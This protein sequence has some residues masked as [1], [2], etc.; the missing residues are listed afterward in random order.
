MY[1]PP[2]QQLPPGGPGTTYVIHGG[3]DAGARFDGNAPPSIPPPP[4]GIAPN[5]AQMAAAS[6]ANVHITQQQGDWMTGGSDGGY[7]VW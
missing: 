3:F 1:S 6:G 4:P 5:A 2:Q 7:T